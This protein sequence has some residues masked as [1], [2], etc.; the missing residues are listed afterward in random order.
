MSLVSFDVANRHAREVM[1]AKAN[2][3]C[4]SNKCVRFQASEKGFAP[5][6]VARFKV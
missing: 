6:D 1:P 4:G 2:D 3:A 5:V